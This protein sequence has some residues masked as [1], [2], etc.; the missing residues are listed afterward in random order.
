[1]CSRHRNPQVYKERLERRKTDQ[2]NTKYRRSQ[3]RQR[4]EEFGGKC[5][6]CGYNR[7]MGTL[8][9]HH[10]D[11]SLKNVT[12]NQRIPG[13]LWD[14]EKDNLVLVCRN[15]HMEIHMGLR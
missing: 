2:V 14:Q 11:P 13:W 8:D 3:K 1:M 6:C 9:F 7:C 10:R 15:C 4:V 5:Q 12:F